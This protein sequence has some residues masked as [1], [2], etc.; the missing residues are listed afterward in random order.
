[1]NRPYTRVER[2]E[3]D[4]ITGIAITSSGRVER[5]STGHPDGWKASDGGTDRNAGEDITRNKLH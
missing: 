2:D 5:G 1:M 4:R 3:K